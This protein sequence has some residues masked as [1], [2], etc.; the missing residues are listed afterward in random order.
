M[1]SF[2]DL[3]CVSATVTAFHFHELTPLHLRDKSRWCLAVR[4]Q[5][6][7]KKNT[8]TITITTTTTT[9][10]TMTMTMTMTATA[11]IYDH[12]HNRKHNHKKTTTTSKQQQ[13]TNHNNIPIWRGSVSTSEEPSPNS[14]ELN[15]ALS[16]VGDPTQS[17][18]SRPMSSGHH[19]ASKEIFLNEKWRKTEMKNTI[20]KR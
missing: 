19:I 17:Q 11:T 20:A 9:T 3:P 7:K 10:M 4:R 18:L 14:G 16:Q 5:T 2:A 13:Q 1:S 8:S 12:D 15:H 6:K